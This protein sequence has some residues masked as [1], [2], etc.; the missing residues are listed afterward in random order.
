MLPRGSRL[1]RILNVTAQRGNALTGIH[2]AAG[3]PYTDGMAT[4]PSNPTNAE[5]RR[6]SIRLPRPLWIGLAALVLI[7]GAA[8][9]HIG[10]LAYRQHVA[11]REIEAG[12]GGIDLKLRG[13]D[14]MRQCL[15]KDRMRVF[16]EVF[17]VQLIGS[18]STDTILGNLN[19]L[20]S[21]RELHAARSQLSDQ[22][23][24]HVGAVSGL[25]F[26]DIAGTNVTDIGVMRI[27]GS[28]CLEG[29]ILRSTSITDTG[30][31]HLKRLTRLRHLD[32][33]DTQITDAG[34]RHLQDL[35][36][37]EELRLSRTH[38]TDAGLKHL[39]RLTGLRLL[40]L[41]DTQV[42]DT[43]IAG[44]QRSLPEIEVGRW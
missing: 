39:K 6:F 42:T 16:D 13:P 7:V 34:L 41:R 28:A 30:L 27:E 36:S 17:Y 24:I 21:L 9:L 15:G 26:L 11:I 43:G 35:T 32:L 12:G 40:W 8:G 1:D 23:M 10:L 37:L 14:W 20:P 5:P 2:A 3:P 33:R 19:G 31:E 25:E 29:L 4:A 44:V 18:V 22:G 38:V